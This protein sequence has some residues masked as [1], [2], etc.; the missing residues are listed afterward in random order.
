MR[1]QR[2]TNKQQEAFRKLSR[3]ITSTG[4]SPTLEEFRMEL[5][6]KSLNSAQQYINTFEKLGLVRRSPFQKRGIEIVGSL[7]ESR[8]GI[9]FLP[10]IASAGCDAMSI[11]ADRRFDERLGVDSGFIPIGKHMERLVL[12]KAI[13][14]SM[15]AAGISSGDYVLTEKT[16]DI[17]DGDKVVATIG[18][19]AVI[20]KIH[21]GRDAVVLKPESHDP[22]YREII[23]KDTGG[24]FGKVLDVIRIRNTDELSYEKIHE[25]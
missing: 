9:V 6:L 20:K 16:D 4:V 18:D 14:D 2:L 25:N 19:M 15:D 5:G 24:V 1:N 8:H 22:R 10:V 23:M 21:F 12:F 7:N 11:F 13:G 3:L 17:S